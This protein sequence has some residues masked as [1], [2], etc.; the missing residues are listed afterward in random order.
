MLRPGRDPHRFRLPQGEGVD[1]AS[2]PGAAG[3]A[4]AI[5]HS[6]RRT[7]NLDFDRATKTASSMLHNP[8]VSLQMIEK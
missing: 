8:Y 5:A 4:M 6:F 2:G 1:R 7:R 3:A